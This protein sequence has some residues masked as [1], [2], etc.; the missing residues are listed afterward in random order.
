MFPS[1]G[2]LFP[3]NSDIGMVMQMLFSLTFIIYLFYAQ[4]IQ[5]MTMLRQIE[6]TLRKVKAIRDEGR[7]ISIQT[8]NEIGKP[9]SDPTPDVERF[10][11]HFLIPPVSLD[12]A[13]IVGKLEQLLD[14]RENR[15]EAEVRAMAPSASDSDVNN[16]EN[17]L[18]A[19]LALNIYYKV[20]RHFYLLGKKT[21]NIYVIMQIHMILPMIMREIKAFSAALQAFKEG[22]PIG[23]GVGAL[24]AAKL[25]HGHPWKEVG[26]D[27]I[28]A[29]V[30]MSGRTL[31]V[32]KA[33]GPG[34]NVG[35][36]GK[37][38]QNVLNEWKGRVTAIIMID[39]AGK[40]EG[41]P[42]GA[43]AEG[44]G[45]AIGG[46]GVQKF[47]IEEAA[48]AHDVP[49]Y[50]VAIKEDISHVVAP[51]EEVLFDAADKALETVR[52]LIEEWTEEDDVVVI[53]GI[54]NTVGIAQ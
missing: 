38:I 32:M 53:A 33:R 1:V 46:A 31:V 14:V 40:L 23:D 16:L 43:I 50:A 11:E 29:Q 39:A 35:K 26:K 49:L 12:P 25:M 44:V 6:G 18:E 3:P 10:L 4:R 21:M 45:A 15:F 8:I 30:P 9:T 28:A 41:E 52:R 47:M 24:A 42:T 17:L 22:M 19:A 27:M 13:G 48:K 34:G 5:S 36:P 7:S 37:A 2:Q 54:G 51:M 20:I